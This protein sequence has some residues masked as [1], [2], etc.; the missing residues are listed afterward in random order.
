MTSDSKSERPETQSLE[1]LLA[2]FEIPVQVGA[3]NQETGEIITF[4]PIKNGKSPFVSVW[5][6]S[7]RP[8]E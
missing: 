3:L 7:D 6:A 5:F 1:A 2:L 8:T 4:S